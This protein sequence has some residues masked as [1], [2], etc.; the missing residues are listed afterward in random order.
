MNTFRPT[1]RITT[2]RE[3]FDVMLVDGAAYQQCEWETALAA[4]YERNDEGDWLFQGQPFSGI[5]DAI[6]PNRIE[7]MAKRA[8]LLTGMTSHGHACKIACQEFGVS[9]EDLSAVASLVSHRV[10]ELQTFGI[11]GK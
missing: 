2:A 1:H 4:D 5:V 9:A 7:E 6:A 8:V 10:T 11:Y 3:T